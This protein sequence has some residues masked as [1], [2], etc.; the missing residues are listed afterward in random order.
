MSSDN[1]INIYETS[2]KSDPDVSDAKQI[3]DEQNPSLIP[4]KSGLMNT[5]RSKVNFSYNRPDAARVIQEADAY[6]TLGQV[7]PGGL[8][9]GKGASGLPADTIDLVVG[10]QSSTNQGRGPKLNAVVDNSFLSD[11]AR[12]YICRNTDIDKHFGL[13]SR[14]DNNQGRGSLDRSA[15]G[16][17]A[18]QVRVIGREGIKIVTGPM[19]GAV[20]GNNAKERLSTGLT[21]KQTAPPIEFIAGNNYDRVQGIALGEYTR[22]CFLSVIGIIEELFASTYN[23]TTGQMQL[24]TQLGIG[25]SPRKS[26]SSKFTVSRQASNVLAPLY[27]SRVNLYLDV[28]SDHLYD[29]GDKYLVSRHVRAN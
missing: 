3:F 26:I 14:P 9:T 21:M 18:D 8:A 6:I 10:R 20:I 11:S 4:T 29:S 5:V 25:L 16:I 7:P 13:V 28:V 15:V 19:D 12:V 2:I 22:D 24:N 17:K 23:L 27:H 1:D